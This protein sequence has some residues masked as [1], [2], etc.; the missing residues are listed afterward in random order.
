MIG[1]LSVNGLD[2]MMTVE[3]GT[4]TA[5]F[6]RFVEDHLVPVLERGDVVV[7]DNLAAHHARVVKE[8]IWRAG[9][10]ILFMPPYSPDLNPIELCWSKVKQRL[11]ALGARTVPRLKRAIAT[12]AKEVTGYDTWSWLD[13]C[14]ASTQPK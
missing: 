5:V 6:L 9:A 2:A 8:A 12:A 1:G 14:L 13:H 4:T 10:R 7:M 3:G 11:R